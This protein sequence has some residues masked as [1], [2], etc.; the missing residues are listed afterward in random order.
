VTDL[1]FIVAKKAAALPAVVVRRNK[2][3]K[4]IGEQMEAA[5][6][7]AAGKP[8]TPLV[9]RNVRGDDGIRRSIEVTKRVRPWHWQGEDGKTYLS[10]RYGTRELV[11]E[12][13]AN[14]VLIAKPDDLLPTLAALKDMAEAGEFDA[15]IS[16]ASPAQVLAFPL[17]A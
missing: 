12:K 10:L 9:T 3:I 4:G 1:K 7:A 11:L 14:A 17:Q 5:K 8:Y 16:A 2:L 15:A 13:G 6:A